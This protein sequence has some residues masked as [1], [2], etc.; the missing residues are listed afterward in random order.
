MFIK[1]EVSGARKANLPEYLTSKGHTLKR[2][3]KQFRVEGATGLIV[4]GC[5]WY[6]HAQQRGGNALDY[7]IEM[8]GRPFAEAV[9]ALKGFSDQ[10]ESAGP[11]KGEKHSVFLLPLRNSNDNRAIS[12]LVKTRGIPYD[13]LEPYVANGRVY[14]SEKH[15]CVFTGVDHDT[16]EARYA[17][18]R[19]T[20]PR[21]GI[22]FE[23]SGSDK[24]Y[25]FSI[26]GSSEALF[27]FESAIDLFSYMSMNVSGCHGNFSMLSLGGLSSTALDH[28]CKSGSVKHVV[29][30]LDNDSPADEAYE[31]MG[32]KYAS[33]GYMV[34]RHIPTYK[35]WNMQI[36]RG[37]HSFS[38]PLVKWGGMS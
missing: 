16:G 18:Q 34:Y 26:R 9:A 13:V 36:L 30:C 28:F 2:E 12:Y 38:A 19:S 17:F 3:G 6:S 24:R 5:C 22:M 32:G 27:I 7:V 14:E 33:L 29:F 20:I 8:E 31:R 10:G 23:S 11:G 21:S 37:G 35:D 4:T 1:S 15:N 25:S